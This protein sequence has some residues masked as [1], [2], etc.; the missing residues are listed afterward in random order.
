MSKRWTSRGVAPNIKRIAPLL[1]LDKG[2]HGRAERESC[3]AV[4]K[5]IAHDAARVDMK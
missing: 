5:R 2:I 4:R 1:F 3:L